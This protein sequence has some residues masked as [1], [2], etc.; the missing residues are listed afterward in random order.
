[1]NKLFLY[2]NI[3]LLPLSVAQV[4]PEVKVIRT[5]SAIKVDGL[6][7]ESMWDKIE[8]IT[9]FVQRLPQDGAQPTEKSE[10]RILFDDNNLY[11]GFTFFDS[12]P[13]KVRATILNRGG[14]IHRDDKLEIALDTYLDRRNAYL[15]E[16][17]PLGTQDDALITDENRPS[18]DEWAWDGIYL[19]EGRITDF[20][21]VLE[22]AIPWNT[23]RF[24][25]KNEL[26]MGI[27]VKRYINRKNESVMW[28]H[29]GLDYSSDIY[30]VSQ[31][32]NLTGIKNIKRGNDIKIKPF[33][34]IGSQRQI[35]GD[36]TK[37]DNLENGGVD[38]YYG[39]KSNL[40]LN[41]TYNTDFA[42]VEADNAQI[43]LNRFNLFYPEKREFFLTR[44]KLFSFGNSR[45]TEIFFSRRIGLNQNVLGGSRMYGQVGKTSIG[46]LNIHT[47]AE[48]GLPATAYS[49]LRLRSNVRD[50]TTIGAIVTDVSNKETQNSV[51]GFDGQMRFWGNSSISAWYSQVKDDQFDKPSEASHILVDLK[52]D[53]YFFAAGQHR[54]DK[55][56]HPSLGFVQRNDMVENRFIMGFTPRVGNGEELIRQ[57]RYNLEVRDVKNLEGLSETRIVKGGIDAIFESRDRV[58]LKIIRQKETLLDGFTLVNGLEILKGDYQDRKISLSAR[59]NQSR[60]YWGNFSISKGDYFGGNKTSWTSSIGKQFS[61]HLTLY[62]SANQN[63]I[64][65]PNQGEFTANIYGL[66][67]EVALNRKWFGKALIQYDNFSNQLQF[68]CRIN[69]IHTPGSDLFIVINKLYDMSGNN[70]DQIQNT[71]VLKLTYLF[72]I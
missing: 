17:N 25:N 62:G 54:V 15:F 31:Y 45:Q 60:G 9:Q 36:E 29:I 72:Q 19:S 61:N 32:A 30:Q 26:I 33:G 10:M 14:Y 49:A 5:D 50:R 28:P 44:S 51:I 7:D 35:S 66:T 27:A 56:F 20:G 53:R 8:P 6:L 42:Q 22:V 41:L 4:R 69:W 47:Q 21:W 68:Y 37:S 65:M 52:N 18:L 46:A 34:I 24:P 63:I 57:M 71:Q 13:E 59:T 23:L 11:F 48:N 55:D 1:L 70:N 38:L 3:L 12:E 2:I 67:A 58:G 43:N 39:L 64:F 16:M 40:T